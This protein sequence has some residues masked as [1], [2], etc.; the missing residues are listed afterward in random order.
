MDIINKYL[1]YSR[2][3]SGVINN[4]I[5]F[6]IIGISGVII[7]FFI[8]LKYNVEILG[9]FNQSLAVYV[10]LSQISNFGLYYSVL[11]YTSDL[12]N[13]KSQKIE[14]IFSALIIGILI[15]IPIIVL[16]YYNINNIIFFFKSDYVGQAVGISSYALI[17]FS[18][19]KILIAGLNG[20]GNLTSV[21][22]FNSIRPILA[23]LFLLVIIL[24]GLHEYYLFFMF[25]FS[26]SILF[27]SMMIHYINKYNYPKLKNLF[28]HFNWHLSYGFK[29][30]SNALL[31]EIN[32]KVD[33][34]LIGYIFSDYVAGMYSI[35][36]MIAEGLNQI[37]Q[38][39]MINLNHRLSMLYKKK[40]IFLLSKLI[41]TT[42]KYI[43]S[44]SFAA[45]FIINMIMVIIMF[46]F[47]FY[48]EYYLIL[49][50]NL[51][52]S[53][54]VFLFSGFY[55]LQMIFTQN[56]HPWSYTL[57]LLFVFSFNVFS[58]II[59]VSY[60]SYYGV[61]LGTAITNFATIFFLKY[62]T[63]LRLNFNL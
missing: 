43:Y 1:K 45:F 55:P 20:L 51:I 19:N 12:T 3:S 28:N 42:K 56:N 25:L 52:L 4:S 31:I 34:M 23:V 18:A 21:A 48:D 17:F 39:F 57:F 26:E 46:I 7:N 15:P 63:R 38:V 2:F 60:Y 32:P 59:L 35:A 6:I 10:I 61:A 14:S 58:S 30:V 29:S 37:P 44:I 33:I 47:N 13:N 54:G 22:I 50:F 27:F 41:S 16:V 36:S 8:L 11:N 9:V 24:S 40:K 62:F 5:S 53:L 49:Q